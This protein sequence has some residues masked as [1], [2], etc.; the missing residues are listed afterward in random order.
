MTVNPAV[1]SGSCSFPQAVEV[2]TP[3][4]PSSSRN[5]WISSSTWTPLHSRGTHSPEVIPTS[6]IVAFLKDAT[7]RQ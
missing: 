4:S 7:V 2:I 6:L 1:F 3:S 5:L